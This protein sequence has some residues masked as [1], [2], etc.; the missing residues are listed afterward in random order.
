VK[1]QDYK[2][3]SS[4]SKIIFGGE[5]ENPDDQKQPPPKTTDKPK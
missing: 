3:F 4:K 1:Y 5:V 2:K